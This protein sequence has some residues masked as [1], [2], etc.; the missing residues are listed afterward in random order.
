MRR[1][2][3][4]VHYYVQYCGIDYQCSLQHYVTVVPSTT[5]SGTYKGECED[6]VSMP[7]ICSVSE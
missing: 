7:T 4:Y 5:M 1:V 2:Q 6:K 3:K